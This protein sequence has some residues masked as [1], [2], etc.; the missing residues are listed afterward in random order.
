MTPTD[1]PWASNIREATERLI[2]KLNQDLPSRPT[3][4]Q[5]ELALLEHHKPLLSDVMQAISDK[6]EP[7]P[8]RE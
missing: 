3:V 7:F 1:P 8:P 4:E 6:S 2:Q 5:I